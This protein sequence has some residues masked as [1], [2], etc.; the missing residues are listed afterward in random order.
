M[1]LGARE[2][3]QRLEAVLAAVERHLPAGGRGERWGLGKGA[4]GG[5][6]ARVRWG[7]RLHARVL[8]A[9]ADCGGAKVELFSD[10]SHQVAQRELGRELQRAEQRLRRRDAHAV[11]GHTAHAPLPRVPR[12]ERARSLSSLCASSQ[13]SVWYTMSSRFPVLPSE[14]ASPSTE[15][16][17]RAPPPRPALLVSPRS[18]APLLDAGRPLPSP[19]PS[20]LLSPS[21]SCE[22]RSW[23]RSGPGLPLSTTRAPPST[24]SACTSGSVSPA[25]RALACEAGAS[26]SVRAGLARA[27]SERKQPQRGRPATRTGSPGRPSSRITGP[28]QPHSRQWLLGEAAPTPRSIRVYTLAR[29]FLPAVKT[30]DESRRGSPQ[31]SRVDSARLKPRE[32]WEYLASV[33]IQNI[34]ANNIPRN[35]FSPCACTRCSS[36]FLEEEK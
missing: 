6:R 26:S 5:W 4:N 29:Y 19:L 20:P 25:S 8:G 2:E 7:R 24:S 14:A 17:G 11:L 28:T 16:T 31:H 18:G 22:V 33:H 35:I 13:H 27:A 3:G 21:G 12:R 32:A 15:R 10:R 23:I 9:A 34:F 1:H 30:G 36:L